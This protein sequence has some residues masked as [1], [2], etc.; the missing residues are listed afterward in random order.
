MIVLWY[1]TFT[2]PLSILALQCKLIFLPG[3]ISKNTEYFF[4]TFFSLFPTH[5]IHF[6][7]FLSSRSY[8]PN[9]YK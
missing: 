7:L 9:L 5:M 4:L 6:H 2:L 1:I 3:G 8:V